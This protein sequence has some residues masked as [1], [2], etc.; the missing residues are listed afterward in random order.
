MSQNWINCRRNDVQAQGLDR[1]DA[2]QIDRKS[3]QPI[4]MADHGDVCVLVRWV[5]AFSADGPR[6]GVLPT[7]PACLRT[8]FTT[9]D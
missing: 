8:A 7:K 5:R 1:R 2:L 6:I 9:T 3:V 4:M